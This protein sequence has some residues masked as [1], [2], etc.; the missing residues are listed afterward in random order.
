[1]GEGGEVSEYRVSGLWGVQCGECRVGTGVRVC[2]CA[3][4]GW[5]RW[6]AGGIPVITCSRCTRDI[7]LVTNTPATH[8]PPLTHGM[9]RVTAWC[10]HPIHPLNPS[11]VTTISGMPI[12]VALQKIL[13]I[14]FWN[15]ANCS[16]SAAGLDSSPVHRRSR[17]GKVAAMTC[18]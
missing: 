13:Q 9:G 4:T 10:R 11:S 16:G 17:M 5:L 8:P 3:Q 7:M 15:S 6:A 14:S 12:K 2:L 1:M 18:K